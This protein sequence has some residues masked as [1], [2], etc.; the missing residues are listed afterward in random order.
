[1]GVFCA[2][3]VDGHATAAPPSS[4]MNCR[5]LMALPQSGWAEVITSEAAQQSIEQ[6]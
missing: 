3:A 6:N 4:A 1:M 2:R 5:R